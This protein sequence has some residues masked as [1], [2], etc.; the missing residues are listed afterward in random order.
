MRVLIVTGKLSAKRAREVARRFSA[1][2]HVAEE[3]V[4]SLLTPEKIA[5]SLGRVRDADLVLVPGLVKGDV[6]S[7]AR[8]AGVPVYKGTRDISDLEVLLKNLDR[9][10][11]STTAPADSLLEE[12]IRQRVLRELKRVDSARVKERLLKRRWN[13]LIG[14]LAVGRDFPM[15]IMAEVVGIEHL[16][17]EEIL[18]QATY[19]KRS[20]ADI[21]DLG[22]MQPSPG[23]VEEVIE[24][25]KPL[26]VPLSVDT[27]EARNLEAA[28]DAGADLL[29]SFDHELL[30][31]FSGV[32]VPSV[33][34]PRRGREVPPKPEQRVKLLEENIALA[35]EQGFKKVIAD[36]LL[37]PLNFGFAE[38]VEAYRRF[39]ERH[40]ERVMLFGLGNVS[41]LLDADSTGVNAL[42]AGIASEVG[43]SILFTPEASGKTR[44][45]VRELNIAA[46]MMFL[47]KRRRSLPKD[48]GLSL[49]VCKE[50]RVRREPLPE[51]V[52]RAKKIKA[53]QS[54]SHSWDKKGYFK[55]YVDDAIYCA[56]YKDGKLNLVVTGESAREIG[57]TLLRLDLVGELSH[58][59]YLGRE[60]QRAEEALR[61]RRSYVQR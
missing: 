15:R 10:E 4:A 41:E 53:E 36:P 44:G 50:K 40:P 1:K 56:H 52:R 16:S 5:R 35:E 2:V 48:L 29:L 51:D 7:V 23:R 58:A 13:M 37:S 9:V 28:I 17:D 19:F 34:I 25:L 45:S 55:I 59:L 49:L 21:I 46:K 47:A 39:G 11:L 20:G 8:T 57:D 32:E 30:K 61:F 27:M 24:L 18:K 38:S 6:S 43:A 26:G 33:I 14:S 31:E 3:E 42:L 12:A 54:T 22:I 60:L